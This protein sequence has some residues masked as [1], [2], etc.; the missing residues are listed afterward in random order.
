M[1]PDHPTGQEATGDD[2]S[3]QSGSGES[4]S[5]DESSQRRRKRHRK[6]IKIRKKVRIKRKV[7]PKK[8]ARKLLETFAWVLVVAAFII[9]LVILILQLDFNSKHRQ[10]KKASLNTIENYHSVLLKETV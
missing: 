1:D 6:R 7:S 9:T 5:A 4:A 2:E 3:E 8:K 10:K